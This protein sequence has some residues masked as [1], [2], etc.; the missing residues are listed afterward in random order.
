MLNKFFTLFLLLLPLSANAGNGNFTYVVKGQKSP[1]KGTLFDDEATA[2]LMTLPEYYEQQCALE[3]QYKI[4]LMREEY[5]FKIKDLD[6]QVIYLEKE[7]KTISDQKDDRIRLLEEQ[8]KKNNK[9]DKPWIF[10]AGVGIG[11]GLTVAIIKGLE[12]P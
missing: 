9:N 5:E 7:K 12:A 8:L 6:Q 2:H 4:G 11:V 3:M 1:F 10:A